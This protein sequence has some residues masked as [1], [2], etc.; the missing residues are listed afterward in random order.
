MFTK[1]SIGISIVILSAATI[2][3]A[4]APT[5]ISPDIDPDL[6]AEEARA[7]MKMALE[8]RYERAYRLNRV[9]WPLLTE[10]LELCPDEQ[11][12]KL[13]ISY[14]SLERHEGEDYSDILRDDFN[15]GMQPTILYVIPGSP[16]ELAGMQSGDRI[17]HM[18]GTNLG[19]GEDA[20]EAF[21]EALQEHRGGKTIDLKIL[22]DRSAREF[23]ISPKRAC[24]YAVILGN[25]SGTSSDMI[26]AFADGE[27]VYI[28]QGMMRFIKSD[29]E[30]ALVV[31]HELAHNSRGHI[32][33]QLNNALLGGILGAVIGVAVGVDLS[34]AGARLGGAAFSQEFET[35]ADY[36]GI[37]YAA[38]AGYDVRSAAPIWRRMAI[39]HPEGIGLLGGTH[40]STAKRFLFIDK[41][42]EEFEMKREKGLP[43]LP[44]DGATDTDASRKA[45]AAQG[46]EE[47]KKCIESSHGRVP[48]G[49]CDEYL[50]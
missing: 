18:N 21:T 12:Y 36:V 17:T 29:D 2:L 35:E 3:S 13:G 9:S 7:Q 50:E 25:P 39:E 28:T 8:M 16:A 31:G 32:D 38:R 22:R 33:D 40:P 11:T 43:L 24:N 47:Y 27:A 49:W 45:K 30:L 14:D 1:S 48:V 15:V 44:F 23:A 26:N 19:V 34:D 41:A 4:C 6:S 37:Y 42:V 10:N 5:T 20:M 46:S